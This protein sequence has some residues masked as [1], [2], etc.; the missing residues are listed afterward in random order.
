MPNFEGKYDSDSY[1]D[2]DIEVEEIIGSHDFFEHKKI[3][4]VT[5]RFF[6]FASVWWRNYCKENIYNRPATWKALKL[7]MRN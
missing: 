2:W 7:I 5:K 6:G 4:D 1:I 3:N